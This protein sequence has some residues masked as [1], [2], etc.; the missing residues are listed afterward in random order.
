MLS[1]GSIVRRWIVSG[2]LR[3]CRARSSRCWANDWGIEHGLQRVE[4]GAQG[5]H[6]IQRGYLPRSTYSAHWIAHSGLRRAIANFVVDEQRGVL[7]EMAAL[8]EQSP[9]R[10]ECEAE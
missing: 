9:F 3:T 5:R 2:A 7:A 1:I 4:A 8:S 6:K 10:N